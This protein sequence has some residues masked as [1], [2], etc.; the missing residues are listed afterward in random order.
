VWNSLFLIEVYKLF[1]LKF[2]S[3]VTL[4]CFNIVSS[5]IL[6]LLVEAPKCNKAITLVCKKYD[7]VETSVIINDH[8][9]LLVSIHASNSHGP[10]RS[11]CI[12]SSAF[13]ID[14]CFFDLKD[15]LT[16]F[17]LKLTSQMQ[18]NSH[19][20]LRKPYTS[21]LFENLVISCMLT[22]P[23]LLCHNQLWA[24]DHVTQL[25]M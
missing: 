18:L 25:S 1:V 4:N 21:S 22:W 19:L 10:K 16:C 8:V 23:S 20:M 5:F 3:M 24:F 15:F 12:S 11:M 6:N 17:P 2:F 13:V 7:P 9:S 14:T